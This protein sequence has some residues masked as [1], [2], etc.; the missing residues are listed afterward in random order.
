[1]LH[2]TGSPPKPLVSVP[3]MGIPLWGKV[4]LTARIGE[5]VLRGYRL[6]VRV[7]VKYLE[8]PYTQAHLREEIFFTWESIRCIYQ[9]LECW[10]ISYSV[11]SIY[12]TC[13]PSSIVPYRQSD[14]FL[15]IV[16]SKNKFSEL[17]P[18]SNKESG[19]WLGMKTTNYQ[20]MSNFKY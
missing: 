19:L 13:S 14:F 4:I 1:M 17:E 12:K 11:D 15:S 3:Y 18:W 10:H 2:C 5:M 6:W 8:S 7:P 9:I 20:R 16:K